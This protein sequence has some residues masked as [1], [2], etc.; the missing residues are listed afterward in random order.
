MML[1]TIFHKAAIGVI[2]AFAAGKGWQVASWLERW[3]SNWKVAGS[4]PRADKVKICG[5]AP[6]QGS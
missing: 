1:R 6:V 2:E 4:N 5:S 3:G